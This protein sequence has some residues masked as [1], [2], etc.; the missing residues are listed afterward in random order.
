MKHHGEAD[1]RDLLARGELLTA[2]DRASELLEDDP[3]DPILRYLAALALART[4]AVRQA[5]T[6][7]SRLDYG[8]M[9]E[10]D[11]PRLNEDVAALSAR[12]VKDLAMCHEGEPRRRYASEAS[13][14]YEEVY[15]IHGGYFACINAATMAAVAGQLGRSVKLAAEALELVGRDTPA[16]E[17]DQYWRAATRAEATLL[18]GDLAATTGALRE[19]AVI[20]Q[21]NTAWRATTRRQ[22]RLICVETGVDPALLDALPVPAV[23]H[24]TGHRFT[25]ADEDLAAL[26]AAIDHELD[27]HAAGAAFGALA[28]GADILVAEQVLSR[29]GQLH[30]LLPCPVD[31]FAAW[32]VAPGGPD[33]VGRFEECLNSAT[34]V[35]CDPSYAPVEDAV[36]YGYG[37]DLAMG[38]AVMHADALTGAAFQ[39]ALWDGEEGESGAGTAS[40]VRQWRASGRETVVIPCRH[41]DPPAVPEP[42]QPGPIMELR[43]LMFADF[44]G[45]S[46]LD[47]RQVLVF[48]DSVMTALSESIDG[49]G[50][51]VLYRNSWGDGLYLVFR[52]TRTATVASLTLQQAFSDLD[53]EALGL[54]PD[55]GLRIGV[56]SGPVY[57]AEDPIRREPSYFGTH[58]TRTARIEPRTPT[59]EVFMTA[60][61]AALLALD[62]VPGMFPEYV[63]HI[64]TAK[65][66]G[67]FPM[68]ALTR[69]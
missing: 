26:R 13:H 37:A 8:R 1:V 54:P 19:G 11:S 45:F 29:G 18:M 62:P 4:G 46:R 63:G 52:S 57:A 51:E 31:Q 41:P 42:T 65:G 66:F 22:L 49:F 58:V 25:E 43:A 7:L 23:L 24:F 20:S 68:Y 34:S 28:Y 32:S 61:S 12:L 21:A 17:E 3:A 6:E 47:E 30:V 44:R 33:W 35:W 39:L 67:V 60:S 50:D 56:H 10:L 16:S 2:Y 27:N 48:F 15:R 9:V 14:R 36:M 53:L 69:R 59:G 38:H 40:D 64:A 55:M 5:G